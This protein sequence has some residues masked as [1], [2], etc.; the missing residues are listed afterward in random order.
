[1]AE[2]LHAEFER[3]GY[4]TTSDPDTMTTELQLN[5][6]ANRRLGDAT[7]LM[8]NI[9]TKHLMMDDVEIERLRA[10]R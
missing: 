4:G 1:M 5:V 10:E 2:E 7:R 8:R 6:V 9:I 3:H